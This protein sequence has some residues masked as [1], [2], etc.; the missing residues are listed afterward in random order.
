MYRGAKN[1]WRTEKKTFSG[2]GSFE[3]SVMVSFK[4][5][6]STF[7]ALT[8]QPSLAA[9]TTVFST[10]SE[11][12][13]GIMEGISKI[14]ITEQESNDDTIVASDTGPSFHYSD[15]GGMTFSTSS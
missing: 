10:Y 8:D 13:D 6:S 9:T 4:G 11:S 12:S 14:N 5:G 15:D 1:T 3:E 7:S 2:G